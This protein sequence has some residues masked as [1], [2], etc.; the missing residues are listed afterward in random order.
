MVLQKV[1]SYLSCLYVELLCV[2]FLSCMCS[3]VK[4]CGYGV[5]I[6]ALEVNLNFIFWTWPIL[7]PRN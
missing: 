3:F 7:S 1:A 2:S 5:E 6:P 4:V